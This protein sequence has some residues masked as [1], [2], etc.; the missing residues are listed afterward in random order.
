MAEERTKMK[1]SK[2]VTEC[3]GP[4]GAWIDAYNR[5]R[6]QQ[7]HITSLTE[8]VKRQ[9]LGVA[10]T[11]Q[12]MQ[13]EYL[14]D[15]AQENLSRLLSPKHT[16]TGLLEFIIDV[17]NSN[18][19]IHTIKC[20]ELFGFQVKKKML[21]PADGKPLQ[22]GD[23]QGRE[24]KF[25]DAPIPKGTFVLDDGSVSVIDLWEEP[26]PV[27]I[28][29]QYFDGPIGGHSAPQNNVTISIASPEKGYGSHLKQE[30]IER[31]RIAIVERTFVQNLAQTSYD[32]LP[33]RLVSEE[34]LDVLLRLC[35]PDLTLRFFAEKFGR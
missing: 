7:S 17:F 13:F 9:E 10:I 22:A 19:R 5:L 30:M 25:V 26:S 3:T 2:K 21:V 35:V 23:T 18:A 11:I 16:D 12:Q 14:I 27:A 8:E 29:E 33:Q 31:V 32:E 24:M 6:G 15:H 28:S 1:N 4:I 20:G 34:A